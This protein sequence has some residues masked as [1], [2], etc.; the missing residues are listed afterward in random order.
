MHPNPYI[1]VF[2]KLTAGPGARPPLGLPIEPQVQDELKNMAQRIIKM[3]QTPQDALREAQ[4]RCQE[5]LDRYEADQARRAN[6]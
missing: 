2:E 3:D 5:Q 6:H 4:A 1:D